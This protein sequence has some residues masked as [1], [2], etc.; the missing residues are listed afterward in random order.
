MCPPLTEHEKRKSKI[1][2]RPHSNTIG[3]IFLYKEHEKWNKKKRVKIT[4]EKLLLS[5]FIIIILNWNIPRGSIC[6]WKNK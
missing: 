2:N 5:R 6:T 4:T 3:K 1:Q